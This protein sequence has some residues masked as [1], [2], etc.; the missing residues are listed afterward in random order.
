MWRQDPLSWKVDRIPSFGISTRT[1]QLSSNLETI[2]NVRAIIKD[3]DRN[4]T[5]S[6]S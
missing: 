6:Q 3:K 2:D 5:L 4:I 1:W